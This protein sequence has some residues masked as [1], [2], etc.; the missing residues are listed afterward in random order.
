LSELWPSTL[1]DLVNSDWTEEPIPS[2][3]ET[4]ME[5]GAAK[6]RVRYTKQR[7]AV[8]YTIWVDKDE[9]EIFFAWY[10][11]TMAFGTKSFEFTHPVKQTPV[12][13]IFKEAPQVS[14]IGPLH[15]SISMNLEET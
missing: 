15:W 6:K 13:Y 4:E 1:Q 9:Y 2:Y 14:S 11:S 3:I 7:Y 12:I 10:E 5:I 8:T